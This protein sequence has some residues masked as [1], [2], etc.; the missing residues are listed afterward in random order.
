MSTE[1]IQ[2]GAT[3]YEED[4]AQVGRR[5]Y[6]ERSRRE[7]L[8]FQRMLQRLFPAP[9]GACLKVKSFPHDLGGYREVCVSYDTKDEA[10]CEYAFMLER[11][12]P[13]KWD[14]IACY[15]LLWSER[16]AHYDEAA[17]KDEITDDEIPAQYLA[18]DFP[19]LP[20]GMSFP[21]LCRQF[22]L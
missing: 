4:C 5:D 11:E 20:A 16:K 10:A 17:R 12:T 3:P 18:E 15:E 14:A 6:P 22:P 7:C 1:I 13:P 21:E 9:D 19:A 2:I 8:V